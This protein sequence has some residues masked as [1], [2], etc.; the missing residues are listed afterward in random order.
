MSGNTATAD[1]PAAS[2]NP[3][4]VEGSGS[5]REAHTLKRCGRPAP[6]MS[7]V[8]SAKPYGRFLVLV[9][10]LY[11]MNA[12]IARFTSAGKPTTVLEYDRSAKIEEIRRSCRTQSSWPLEAALAGT[13]DIDKAIASHE[14]TVS[15]SI[16][17][18]SLRSQGQR[19]MYTTG[20]ESLREGQYLLE[21]GPKDRGVVGET[22]VVD[23]FDMFNAVAGAMDSMALAKI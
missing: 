3:S 12:K 11:L 6:I 20:G 2:A 9:K 17:T 5:L 4:L 10:E 22:G 19:P 1:L 13:F 8:A 18:P 14:K 16:P 23:Q 21:C 7:K 15:K